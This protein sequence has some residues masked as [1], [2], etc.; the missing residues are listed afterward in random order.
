MPP[1]VDDQS[2]R[3]QER[4]KRDAL[5]DNLCAEARL[6]LVRLKAQLA[7]REDALAPTLRA[8]GFLARA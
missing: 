2:H 7:Y 3:A 1:E 6:P 5:V 8:A 4:R